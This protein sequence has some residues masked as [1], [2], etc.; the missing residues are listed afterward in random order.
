LFKTWKESYELQYFKQGIFEANVNAYKILEITPTFD[1]LKELK[2]EGKYHEFAKI[3]RKHNISGKENAFDKLV[4]IFLC[5]IYDETF[6]KNNLKFGYFGV[7]ADTYANM[8]D[9]LMW[10]YKEAMKEFLGE[11]ITFVSNEDIEKDFKQL[12]IKTLKEVMQNY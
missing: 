7:M 4:N 12:K 3:L 11:K 5:K 1:N 6:N 2:E 10:L 9:R 8:Q